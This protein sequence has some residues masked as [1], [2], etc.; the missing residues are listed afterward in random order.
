MHL[1]RPDKLDQAISYL[2][3][4]QSGLWHRHADGTELER[5]SA[6]TAQGYDATAIAQQIKDFR[7]A[8]AAWTAWFAAQGITPLSVTYDALAAHPTDVL[9]RALRHIGKDPKYAKGL[10][11]DTAKLADA[12]NAAWRQRFLADRPETQ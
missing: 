8:D 1:T 7:A 12:T 5:L 6:G 11:P 3:A 2:L 10:G 4:S 9:A